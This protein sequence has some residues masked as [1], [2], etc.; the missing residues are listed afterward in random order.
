MDL[1]ID[2]LIHLRV[3]NPF[4]PIVGYLNIN[5]LRNKIDDLREVCKK[6]QIDILCIDE[7]KL[8]D[9]FP[10]SQFKINGYQFLFLRRDRGNRGGGKT[11]F[12]KQGLIVNRLKQLET[13]ISEAIFLELTISNKKWLLVFA[14][15]APNNANKQLF[16]NE[17]TE[18]LS[19]AVNNYENILLMGDLNINTLTQTNSNNTANHL[20]DFCDL[21]ALSNLV[22][23]KTCTKSVYGTTLDIMLT[24]KPRSF[25]NTSAVTTGLSDCHKLIL[26]CLRAHFKRLP[27]NKIIYRGYIMF[28][29][30]KFLRGLDQEMIKGSFYQHEEA[31]A[32]FSS[33]FRDMVDRHAPLK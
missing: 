1:D 17:L 19:K 23:V 6:V 20:T 16:F 10:D 29:D 27:P 7:T 14:Y 2:G 9:S 5:S 18:S 12:I 30:A 25:Y 3:N 33:V 13:K 8:D 21:F 26:S 15:R 28:D 24:N 31:F 4:N 11:V 32:V 22:N